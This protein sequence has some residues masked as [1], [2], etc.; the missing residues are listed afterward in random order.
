MINTLLFVK[1]TKNNKLWMLLN[2]TAQR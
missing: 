1:F 2:N